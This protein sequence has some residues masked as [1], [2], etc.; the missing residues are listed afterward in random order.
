M[1]RV[2]SPFTALLADFAAEEKISVRRARDLRKSGD[3]RWLN[4]V[5]K[6]A[7]QTGVT[8]ESVGSPASPAVPVPMDNLEDA[9][10]AAIEMQSSAHAALLRRVQTGDDALI[11]SA[12]RISLDAAKIRLD[13]EK[14]LVEQRVKA[15]QL[16]SLDAARRLI[17]R[18]IEPIVAALDGH[19]AACAHRCNPSSPMLAETV[20]REAID[21]LKAHVQTCI[22][23]IADPAAL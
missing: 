15:G 22:Q 23:L 6:R 7:A 18:C 11:G 1:S 10:R 19:P 13:I 20:L 8:P 21:S 9:L 4:W 14:R 16:I 17:G 12:L 3:T 5:N 2:A